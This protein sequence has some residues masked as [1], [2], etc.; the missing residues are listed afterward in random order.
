[1]WFSNNN[2]D[3]EHIYE[4]VID[5]DA[6]DYDSDVEDVG[7]F[8]QPYLGLACSKFVG[9][10]SIYVRS[11]FEQGLVEERLAGTPAACFSNN[12]IVTLSA[13][14]MPITVAGIISVVLCSVHACL[15]A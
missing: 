14:I 11:R 3:G 7:G 13:A 4:D 2:D 5:Y 6:D 15:V 9:N 12:R 10:R 1:M 8:C